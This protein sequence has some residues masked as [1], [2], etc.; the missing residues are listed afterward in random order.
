VSQYA[1]VCVDILTEAVDRLFH[2][3]AS[4][5]TKVGT[6][7]TVPFGS[8]NKPI[9]GYVIALTDDPPPTEAKN[10][11]SNLD[12]FPVFSQE[13]IT[14]AQWM[15]K[16]YYTTLA[17]CLRCI[18]PPGLGAKPRPKPWA[19][20][21][22][23][24]VGLSAA[25]GLEKV[26]RTFSP[27]TPF[28]GI[29][30]L[31]EGQD[32]A[33][34][35]IVKRI[36]EKDTQPVLIHGVTGSG[37]TEVYMRAIARVIESGRQAIMLVPEIAL[38]PQTVS[39]FTERFGDACAV[40]HSRLTAKE[41]L[42]QWQRARLGEVSV[43]IGP[44]SA[45]FA[46]F[47]RL[48]III[49]DEE[50]E[51]TYR[52]ESAPKFDT[53]TVAF[54]RS[55][56][57]GAL[58]V[59]GSATPCL[60]TYYR[61]EAR[62]EFALLEMPQRVNSMFPQIHII[63]MRRELAAGN[64]SVFGREFQDA[65]AEELAKGRQI[66][67]F[68]NRRGHSTFVSCRQCGHVLGCD[69]CRVNFTYHAV[70]EHQL[71]CHYCGRSMRVPK[72]CPACSSPYIRYFGVG[73]QKIE[74]ETARL[75][76]AATALRMD[77]DTTR[78]KHGHAKL[79]GAFRRGEAQILIGTQMIAKGL[80]FPNVTLVGIVAADLSLFSG[81]YRAAEHTFQL[82]TQVSGRAG[83]AEQ[84]GRVFIQTYNPEHYSITLA[85]T[86]DYKAFYAHELTLRR[87]MEYPPFAHVFMILFTG[88]DEREIIKALHKL[89]AIMK[90]CNKKGLFQMLG[91]APAFVSKIKKQFR[92][93]LL[94]K[95]AEEEILLRFV[96]YCLGV[97]KDNDT[98]KGISIGLTLD[99]MAME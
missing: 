58:V 27:L 65:A 86:A 60:E 61:A 88:A 90:Y 30:N 73:T 46:P 31:T 51:H 77:M 52:S 6:R 11:S 68:L 89:A 63:D 39:V 2:Y 14:L 55:E 57:T 78:K 59:L 22:K 33:V 44:R 56:L 42:T 23:D 53:R 29:E 72:T 38:T 85:Q 94:V 67:L 26:H 87:S 48:G 7:V 83:R 70:G 12:D 5:N 69:A 41:R 50:H 13:L 1:L 99:P 80:D 47:S 71:I 64:V 96:L 35:E 76:P 75:F 40:T 98:L 3:K 93:K 37:K 10:I 82:L 81:D 21:Q 91:P 25:R 36:D 66:I 18:L 9:T 8:R 84:S 16:K 34:G 79:L 17:I 49:I 32:Y 54:K 95:S 20:P 28:V 62:K 4:E 24:P 43:M 97:L 15:Q 74:E 92:W 19:P 45:V